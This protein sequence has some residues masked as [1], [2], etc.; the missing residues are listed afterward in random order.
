MDP[1]K[2]G[3]VFSILGGAMGLLGGVVGAYLAIR[4]TRGPRERAFV[5]KASMI[6]SVPVAAFVAAM[7]FIPTWHK[8]LLWIP[9]AALLVWGIRIWNKRQFGIRNEESA[10]AG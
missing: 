4:N 6:C 9:Y 8:H 5:V 2:L 1:E 3:I 7:L 10:D